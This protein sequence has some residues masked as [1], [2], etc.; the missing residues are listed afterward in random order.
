MAIIEKDVEPMKDLEVI[1]DPKTIKILFE[2]TRA[3]MH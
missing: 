3:A 2:P 1:S